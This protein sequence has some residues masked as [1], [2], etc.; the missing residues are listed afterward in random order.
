MSHA[1]R[2][3][4][5]QIKDKYI[6]AHASTNEQ[7]HGTQKIAADLSSRRTTS[8][9]ACAAVRRICARRAQSQ[10]S[11]RTQGSP[12]PPRPPVG[13][14]ARAAL[15]RRDRRRARPRCTARVN[16]HCPPLRPG[17]PRASA[18]AGCGGAGGFFAFGSPPPLV[19]H[20]I[21]GARKMGP[22]CELH[23]A[24]SRK[25]TLCTPTSAPRAARLLDHIE[26]AAW[27]GGLILR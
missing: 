5:A 15:L 7:L 17:P 4:I 19:L 27:R 11:R 10:A 23:V 18:R 3:R 25:H 22:P 1:V 8:V 24:A 16:T 6:A 21:S 14:V 12:C 2:Q 26:P 20:D 13:G 9:A